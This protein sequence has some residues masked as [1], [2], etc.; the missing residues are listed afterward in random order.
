MLALRSEVFVV[1]QACH[2]QDLDGYDQSAHHVLVHDGDRLVG[3]A[4]ILPPGLKRDMPSIGR[5]LLL[6]E[7]RGN[8][9]GRGLFQYCID[10]TLRLYSEYG[11]YI[12]AQYQ[13][14]RF[15]QSMGFVSQ[16]DPYIDAGID[17]VDMHYPAAS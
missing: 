16:G 2:Y 9:Q 5:Y 10:E 11:I 8:G 13:L 15:Y 12:Q 1:E 6:P 7:A 4:R 14:E 17:H 3:C